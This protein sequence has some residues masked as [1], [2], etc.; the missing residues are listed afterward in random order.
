MNILAG[1]N[2]YLVGMMGVGKT[3]VGKVL[4]R[5]L[6]YGFCDTD[7]IIEEVTGCA[8]A[9]I[10]ANEGE[11]QF[12]DIETQVLARVAAHT[13]LVVATGGGIV[14]KPTNWSYLHHGAIVWL[15]ASVD[16]L[17]DRLKTDTFRPLLQNPDPRDTLQKLLDD[18]RSRY[19]LADVRL[20]I[21]PQQDPNAI[22]MATLAALQTIVT[23]DRGD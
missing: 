12:R 10:F 20:E 7:A 22:A 15:D 19:A 2:L 1:A 6:G 5:E 17:Y 3:T 8:I 14:L 13:R 16:L 11:A 9:D 18:R 21:A 4:A 23:V